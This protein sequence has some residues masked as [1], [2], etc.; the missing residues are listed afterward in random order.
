MDSRG[1]KILTIFSYNRKFL[2]LKYFIY[3]TMT[4]NS[5]SLEKK[6]T[7]SDI[8]KVI[9]WMDNIRWNQDNVIILNKHEPYKKLSREYQILVH[10]LCYI[11]DR[12]R[13]AEQVWDRGGYI[14]S[15]LVTDYVKPD[16]RSFYTLFTENKYLVKNKTGK[17]SRFYSKNI[18]QSYAPRFPKDLESI[19]RT[20][21]LLRDYDKSLI[22]YI[23]LNREH[24]EN[25]N[26]DIG[27]ISFLLYCLTYE[28]VE[29]FHNFEKKEF[30]ERM[31]IVKNKLQNSLTNFEDRYSK[32]N[33]SNRYHNKRLW[34]ALRDYIKYEEYSFYFQENVL[35][36]SIDLDKLSQLEFPGDV[37]NK[38]FA[39]RLLKEY[40]ENQK[41]DGRRI[42]SQSN[43]SLSLRLM[44]EWIKKQKTPENLYPEQFDISFDFAP[45]MC[46]NNLC[47]ICPFGENGSTSICLKELSDGK[48]LC[49]VILVTCGYKY[50]CDPKNCPIIKGIAQGT[51]K[52]KD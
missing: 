5:A 25:N 38:R 28:K 6:N 30:I 50:I 24:W 13:T 40:L 33:R 17:M 20:L 2:I 9:Y 10:W 19:L 29:G 32:W 16:S 18:N 26:D 37:W 49:P 11:T 8:W 36:S 22:K 47:F 35:N 12:M 52:Q 31:D 14:F 15:E 43:S 34:A 48:K 4:L 39:N 41:I 44:Y 21:Y 27:R 7:I 1:T 42:F 3:F 46:E 51:C 23:N 45:R